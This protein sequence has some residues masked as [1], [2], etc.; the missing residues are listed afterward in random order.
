M[1]QITPLR[2]LTDDEAGAAVDTRVLSELARRITASDPTAP[3]SL[4]QH[5]GRHADPNARRTRRGR[6]RLGAGTG[7]VGLAAIAAAVVVLVVGVHAPSAQALSF[8]R[9]GD[10]ITII[11][12]NPL[13]DPATFRRELTAHHLHITLH[14]VAASPSI[15]GRVIYV[16]TQAG[17]AVDVIQAHGRCRASAT[18]DYCPVGVRVPV[19]YRGSTAIGFGRPARPGE[20]YETAGVAT[21]PGEAMHGLRYR[22]RTVTTVLAMLARRGVTVPTYR[23]TTGRGRTSDSHV[24]RPDQVPGGW[25]VYGASPWA[26]HQVMLFVGREREPIGAAP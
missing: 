14:L 6:R 12:R 21:A 18:R 23:W 9:H 16:G 5:P 20:R 25:H 26:L 7:A 4:D 1:N 8:T 2:S 15:V 3:P 10:E 13:A 17:A 24:L 22:G 11:V 19:D